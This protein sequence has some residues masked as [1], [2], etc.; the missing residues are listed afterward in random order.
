MPEVV[1][2]FIET[3]DYDLVFKTQKNLNEQY[4]GDIAKYAPKNDKARAINVFDSIHPQPLK[5]YDKFQYSLVEKG[6]TSREYKN[7]VNWIVGSGI[8]HKCY[9]LS[10]LSLPLEG[11]K[12]DDNFKIYMNDIGLLIAKYND[13]NLYGDIL[14][15]KIKD[16]I[17]GAIYENLIATMLIHN[18]FDLFFY[19]EPFKFSTDFVI[20]LN[21][22]IKLLEVKKSNHVSYSTRTIME[23]FEKVSSIKLTN[24][25]IGESSK[26]L[27]IPHFLAMFIK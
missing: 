18:N 12:K 7:P 15:D 25:N 20:R 24:T 22:G 26:I 10:T 19:G 3:K 5:E 16:D 21:N 17:S 11:N 23:R 27:T 9:N 14:N 13:S 1:K 4:R 2:T 8:V 6:K